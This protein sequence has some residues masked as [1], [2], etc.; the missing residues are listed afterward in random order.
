MPDPLPR[1][2]M[3]VEEYLRFEETSPERHE[4]VGGEVYAMTGGTLRHGRIVTNM[5]AILHAAARGGPCSVYAQ[6]VKLRIGDDFYYPDVIVDCEPHAGT[7]VWVGGPC[8][9]IEVHSGSTR[10]TDRREKLEAYRRAGSI[11]SYLMV[12]QD[13]RHVERHWRDDAGAWH[14]EEVSATAGTSAVALPCPVATLT[15]D[16]IYE[17]VDVPAARPRPRRVRERRGT[18]RA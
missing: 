8:V 15:L 6:N 4:F 14:H 5:V 1:G 10:R 11:R 7:E 3:T 2:R 12:E 17:G 9:A 16:E 13:V 18:V